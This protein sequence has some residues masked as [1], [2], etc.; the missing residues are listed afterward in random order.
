M[1]PFDHTP[2]GNQ[3]SLNLNRGPPIKGA[4]PSRRAVMETR[5]SRSFSGLL[6]G[7]AGI[8]L[9]PRRIFAEDE[10]EE[11]VESMEEEKSEKMEVADALAGSCV[12]PEDPNIAL[13]NPPLVSQDDR[14]DDSIYGTPQ[15]TIQESQHSRLHQ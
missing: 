4:A 9:G 12:A 2:S 5:R 15:G 14:A 8:P 11:V 6:G 7:Y 3:V 1:A 10:A 13:S